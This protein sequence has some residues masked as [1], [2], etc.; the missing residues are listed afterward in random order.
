MQSG[1]WRSF[2][3][4]FTGDA[5]LTFVGVPA[6]PFVGRAAVAAAYARQPPSD[7]IATHEVDTNG[8]VDR[9]RFAWT[10]GGTGSMRLSW[11]DGLVTDLEVTLDDG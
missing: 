5:I 8:G 3:D 7:T 6:G 2:A 1:D 11:R 9:V 10:A 4:Q